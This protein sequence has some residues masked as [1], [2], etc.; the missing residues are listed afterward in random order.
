MNFVVVIVRKMIFFKLKTEELKKQ[1]L[2]L[3]QK[4]S[5]KGNNNEPSVLT[6]KQQED[7]QVAPLS[8]DEFMWFDYA[9]VEEKK[10]SEKEDFL[11]SF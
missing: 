8:P 5:K 1:F 3:K 10:L 4:K 11:H 7:Q 2:D 6:Q 9:E